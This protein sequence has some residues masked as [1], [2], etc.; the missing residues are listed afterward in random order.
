MR[1]LALSVVLLASVARANQGEWK[2][3]QKSS[4]TI[5]FQPAGRKVHGHDIE[6]WD[7]ENFLLGCF[8]ADNEAEGWCGHRKVYMTWKAGRYMNWLNPSTHDVKP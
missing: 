7:G 6:I 4:N 5:E 8:I 1:K 3:V 2:V